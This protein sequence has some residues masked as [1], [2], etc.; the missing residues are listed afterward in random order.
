MS[1]NTTLIY[2]LEKGIYVGKHNSD[3]DTRNRDMSPNITLTYPLETG[4]Y[5]TKHNSDSD[6]GNRNT[7]HQTQL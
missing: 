5:V 7:C 3:S 4:I 1:S 6:T 2:P